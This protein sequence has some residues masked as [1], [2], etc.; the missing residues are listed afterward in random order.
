MKKI[1]SKLGYHILQKKSNYYNQFRKEKMAVFAYDDIGHLINL[2]GF[3][4]IEYLKILKKFIIEKGYNNGVFLD[5]GANIGN[6]SIYFQDFFEKIYSIE[7]SKDTFEILK[8]NTKNF[9][10]I[11]ALNIGASSKLSTLR[12]RNNKSNIGASRIVGDNSTYDFEIKVNK[13][14]NIINHK[15]KIK[16]IKI[17]VEGH[18]SHV[19]KGAM[20]IIKQNYPVIVFEQEAKEIKNGSTDVVNILKEIGYKDFFAIHNTYNTSFIKNR[21]LKVIVNFIIGNKLK[22]KKTEYFRSELYNMIIAIK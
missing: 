4:E 14:D 13:L 21:Y 1:I 2:Y 15:K 17:D 11:E 10:N 19:L 5:I 12:F 20:N 22:L 6:H 3:Y 16:L 7:A 8:F 18:E 9:K